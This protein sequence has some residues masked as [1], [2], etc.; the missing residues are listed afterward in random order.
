MPGTAGQPHSSVQRMSEPSDSD[1]ERLAQLIQSGDEKDAP[2]VARLFG[3]L[4]TGLAAE[5]RY[6]DPQ[7][8]PSKGFMRQ[9]AARF[10]RR[11][12]H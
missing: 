3:A 2:E 5:D 12:R 11:K 9:W 8:R 10:R 6:T 1:L 4:E 7:S